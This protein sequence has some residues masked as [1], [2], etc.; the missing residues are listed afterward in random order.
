LFLGVELVKDLKSLEPATREASAI[1]NAMRERGVLLGTDGP[2]HSVLKI[3]PPMPFD[4]QDAE[5]LIRNLDA[6]FAALA[7]D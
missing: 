2:Y 6:A 5:H 1:V 7:A 4:R 3:R